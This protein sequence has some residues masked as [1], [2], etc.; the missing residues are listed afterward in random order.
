MVVVQASELKVTYT[1]MH[2]V[3]KAF[4]LNMFHAFGHQEPVLVKDQVEPDP[5]FPTVAFPN[6]E[7]TDPFAHSPIKSHQRSNHINH[8]SPPIF[9]GLP[10][11]SRT[12]RS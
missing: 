1:A 10:L 12:S 2:G 6:P 4:V 3:G 8:I 5:T 11:Y 9:H 7:V